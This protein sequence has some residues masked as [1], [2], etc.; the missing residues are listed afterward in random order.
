ML[1]ANI[2]HTF[3]CVNIFYHLV[4]FYSLIVY[5]ALLRHTKPAML[6]E[7]SDI[8]W[9]TR[10]RLAYIEARA[11]YA[12]IVSRSD[13]A[14]AFA[15]SD[16]AATK[17]LKRYNDLAPDN[18]VY[19]QSEFGFVA[20]KDFKPH[21]SDLDPAD[22]LP[23]IIDNQPSP[24]LA[25]NDGKSLFGLSASRLPKLTRLPDRQIVAQITRAIYQKSK[26]SILY[27]SLS[28]NEREKSR[29]IEP[30]SLVN[31]GLRWHVR[32]Y[33]E[34][35]FDFRDFVLSRILEAEVLQ[36]KAA[37]T[38]DY[39]EDW[40]ETLT[41]ELAPHPKL[42]PRQ[43]LNLLVDYSEDGG[44]IRLNIRRALLGYALRSLAVDTTNDQSL[45]PN[46]FQL[47]LVNREEVEIYASWAL[48]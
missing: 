11:Y 14:N 34:N 5:Y 41:L 9:N 21:F 32:A 24:W 40:T 13:V 45:N 12:G 43:Q 30:H 26:L 37:S 38:A 23:L 10:Q 6:D 1:K 28:D 44:N 42:S 15:M 3:S 20:S 7:L 18:L 25:S 17:D 27:A 33:N 22:I 31:T 19:K 8:K 46:A 47:V 39:D 36:E 16:P 4:I 2:V 29:I 48:L 35:S